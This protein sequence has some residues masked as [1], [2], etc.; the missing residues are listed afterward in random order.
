MRS[1]RGRD[2][3]DQ[4]TQSWSVPGPAAGWLPTIGQ[5]NSLFI[6]AYFLERQ[7]TLGTLERMAWLSESYKTGV[8]RRLHNEE[9]NDL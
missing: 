4:A 9:L 1:L 2:G 5:E 3:T 6:A 7:L 8:W